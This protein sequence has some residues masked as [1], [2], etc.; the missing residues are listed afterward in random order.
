MLVDTTPG[1]TIAN[2]ISVTSGN[3]A[4]NQVIGGLNASG[5]STF[6]GT[7]T[8]GTG[9]SG[10]YGHNLTL[11]ATNGGE[12]DFT[13][14]VVANLGSTHSMVTVTNLSGAGSAIVKV[15]GNDTYAGGTLVNPNVTYA[16]GLSP[17]TNTLGTSMVTVAGG[18]LALQGQQAARLAANH[19][20]DRL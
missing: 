11:A 4:N 14:N 16:A 9:S 10:D 7:V 8:L 3:T 19:R 17:N 18:T 20:F 5:V 1:R 6:S 2:N 13:G 12:I 15:F